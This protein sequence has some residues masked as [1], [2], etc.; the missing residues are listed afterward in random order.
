[1]V[2]HCRRQ[3]RWAG[4]CCTIVY[5][6]GQFIVTS[7]MV[8]V[9]AVSLALHDVLP[10]FAFVVQVLAHVVLAYVSLLCCLPIVVAW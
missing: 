3:S 10:I 6:V 1:M 9:L 4:R 8:L 2:Q 7:A 5:G